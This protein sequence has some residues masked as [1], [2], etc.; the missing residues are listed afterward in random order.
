MANKTV[1]VCE[2]NPIVETRRCVLIIMMAPS[3]AGVKRTTKECCVRKKVKKH[4][5]INN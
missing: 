1:R 3:P 2:G 4:L 5:N